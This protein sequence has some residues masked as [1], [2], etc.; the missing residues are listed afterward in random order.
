MQLDQ[1]EIQQRDGVRRIAE[2]LPRPVRFL[3]VGGIGL[4]TDLSVFTAIPVHD[5]H[6]IAVRIVSLAVATLVTWRLNRALT[7]D[8]SGRMQG[9][10]AARYAAVTVT[11]QSVGFA[12]FSILVL[13]A[14]ARHPQAALLFG[15]VTSA[16]FSYIGHLFFAFAP[17]DGAS[18][19]PAP[20]CAWSKGDAS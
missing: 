8:P 15:A 19:D 3:M 11:A 20:E 9:H 1:A 10:E 16:L 18:M 13:T 7:F 4:V 12:V 6:P 5:A 2:F 17:D 14:L